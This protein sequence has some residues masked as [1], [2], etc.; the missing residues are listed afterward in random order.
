MCIGVFFSNE[1]DVVLTLD[2]DER[3]MYLGICRFYVI[4]PEKVVPAAQ[5]EDGRRSVRKSL[6]QEKKDI[7]WHRMFLVSLSAVLIGILLILFVTWYYYRTSNLAHSIS[8]HKL[9]HIPYTAIQ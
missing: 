5:T 4:P 6:I 1:E 2:R 8:Y 3:K 7:F 9:S